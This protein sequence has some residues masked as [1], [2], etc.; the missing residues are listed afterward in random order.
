MRAA[1]LI[2]ACLFRACASIDCPAGWT[3]SPNTNKCMKLTAAATHAGCTESC[4]A[5]ASLACIQN[6]EEDALATTVCG[7]SARFV[8]TGEYQWPMEPRVTL[9]ISYPDV[10]APFNGQQGWGKC[11]NGGTTDYSAGRMAT[12]QPNN[13]NGAEDCI[14]RTVIGLA[15]NVCHE[16][17]PCL[18]EWPSQTEEEYVNV[19]GPALLARADEGYRL[20]IEA[21][22]QN[23]VLWITLCCLPALVF[24][25]YVEL[26][27]VRWRQ[28]SDAVTDSEEQLRATTRLALRRNMLQG[29]LSLL[30]GGIIVG[31]SIPPYGL[32]L[33]GSWP[34]YGLGES[35]PLGNAT[36][37]LCM[38]SIG[39]ALILL[40]LRPADTTAIRVTSF[41]F[42]VF[43]VI[44]LAYLR[45]MGG[46]I[47]VGWDREPWHRVYWW[48]PWMSPV[49][50][51]LKGVVTAC[52]L[53]PCVTLKRHALPGRLAL[54]WLWICLRLYYLL[55]AVEMLFELLTWD[56]LGGV[57]AD[58]KEHYVQGF[59]MTIIVPVVANIYVRE[60][61]QRLLSGCGR[62][63]QDASAASVVNDMIGGDVVES[64]RSAHERLYC[65]KLSQLVEADMA[66]N[67]DSG[68]FKKTKRTD[69]GNVHAFLSHSWQ[70][71]ASLKWQAMLDFKSEHEA[72]HNGQEPTCW[73]DKA[74][75]DQA[76]D[77]NLALKVLPLF[78]LFSQQFV[79]FAG[80]TYTL[81]LWCVLEMFTF[82]RSGGTIDRIVLKPLDI[83]ASSVLASFD[84][85]KSDCFMQSD[86]Q[87]LLAIVESSYFSTGA[88]N[89]AC[90]KILLAKLG[91]QPPQNPG[92]T[93]SSGGLVTPVKQM[94]EDEDAD[95]LL[96]SAS[97]TLSTYFGNLIG[98]PADGEHKAED[99]ERPTVQ[100][101]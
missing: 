29:G 22:V 75:I 28:R 70:D 23:W 93:G 12:L 88:F 51:S 24:V 99:G 36:V 78:L 13:F 65:I 86:K 33:R 26:V 54:R 14:G 58:I 63:A 94:A 43:C 31:V 3:G 35:S 69:P 38:R 72:K 18:C 76:G 71:T 82:L 87:R 60:R 10:T 96:Q 73:L 37:Y 47:G 20:M 7:Y 57:G 90:R 101:V 4:G 53:R 68:L 83:D 41:A 25:L 91:H 80:R 79:V 30:L 16:I 81:R 8:W 17:M 95:N 21:I 15:D 98:S 5:D 77:I 55:Y 45:W 11:T 56:S 66:N 59:A 67:Q 64:L 49:L 48:Q 61:I 9:Y 97:R 89:A 39:I 44:D 1:L 62:G 42:F 85:R 27:L 46:T 52:M 92:A 100:S 40:V 32:A 34:V 6:E 84:I 74:C 50:Y 2:I 19:R